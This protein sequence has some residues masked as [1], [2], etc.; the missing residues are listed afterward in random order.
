MRYFLKNKKFISFFW[1][2]MALYMLNISIDSPDGHSNS[3]DEDLSHNEQES[4]VELIIEKVLGYEDA[5]S[6]Y[7]DTDQNTNQKKVFSSE[8][9][10][11]THFELPIIKISP[12]KK[13]RIRSRLSFRILQKHIEIHSPPPDIKFV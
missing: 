10:I 11:L 4:I 7:D 5:I 9:F 12:N 13:D 8:V 1:G 3:V 6:E 2:L